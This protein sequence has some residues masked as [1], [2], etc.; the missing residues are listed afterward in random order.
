MRASRESLAEV[1][2]ERESDRGEPKATGLATSSTA[3][4]G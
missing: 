1:A 2:V 3:Q 4:V